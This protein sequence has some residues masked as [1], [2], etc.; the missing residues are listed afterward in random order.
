MLGSLTRRG[1]LR[2][3]TVVVTQKIRAEAFYYMASK[4]AEFLINYKNAF[5][6]S[7]HV[8]VGTVK[9]SHDYFHR[10]HYVTYTI[11]LRKYAEANGIHVDF[12]YSYFS[13]TGS[14]KKGNLKALSRIPLDASGKTYYVPDGVVK[15]SQGLYVVELYNDVSVQRIIS[16]L[17][18]N[19]VAISRKKPGEAFQVAQNATVMAVFTH[20][21]T[22]QTVM[23]RLTTTGDFSE[24]MLKLFFFATL[25][26]LTDDFTAFR[27]IYNN[28]L[29]F[30]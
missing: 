26:D 5:V 25:D 6:D 12:I 4:G 20:E 15:T 17:Y 19:A 23:Q 10:Y 24:A 7:V 30:L 1:Y 2:K 18:T 27:D 11:L 28:S 8:G 9:V 3:F 29:T 14:N 16:S 21:K 13:K 22:M